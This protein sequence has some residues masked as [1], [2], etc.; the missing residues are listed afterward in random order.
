MT[1][2]R[3]GLVLHGDFVEFPC[4]KSSHVHNETFAV[5][6]RDT[7]LFARPSPS[8][9]SGYQS[10]T[11][12]INAETACGETSGEI[13]VA[14]STDSFAVDKPAFTHL[15]TSQPW[16]IPQTMPAIM[17]SPRTPNDRMVLQSGA[18]R[19]QPT[20]TCASYVDDVRWDGGEQLEIQVSLKCR[21]EEIFHQ[22]RVKVLLGRDWRA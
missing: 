3:C 12:S 2:F 20:R 19:K 4:E 8:N 1:R 22:H 14:A 9:Q 15:S 16:Q 7:V 13:A 5:H 6:F 11:V 18:R 10:M 17:E 21:G